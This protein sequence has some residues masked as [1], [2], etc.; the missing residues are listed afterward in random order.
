MC[1][2]R[3]AEWETV[4]HSSITDWHIFINLWLKTFISINC[5]LSNSYLSR[6]HVTECPPCLAPGDFSISKCPK[7]K[8]V[9]IIL[10][11]FFIRSRVH[12]VEYNISIAIYIS[13]IITY[14]NFPVSQFVNTSKQHSIVVFEVWR[15]Q[16]W[17]YIISFVLLWL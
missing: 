13:A 1:D 9:I 12:I 2:S 3:T 4:D 10:I 6:N 7:E 15:T 16:N 11:V 8:T 17:S 5:W 14:E